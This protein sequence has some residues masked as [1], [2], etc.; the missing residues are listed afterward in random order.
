[1]GDP[2]FRT[3]TIQGVLERARNAVKNAVES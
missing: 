2:G 3:E 1:M